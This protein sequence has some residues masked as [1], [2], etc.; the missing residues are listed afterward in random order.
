[1][2]ILKFLY[3]HNDNDTSPTR[4]EGMEMNWRFISSH[5]FEKSPTRLEGMEISIR[6]FSSL[7]CAWSPTRLEGMEINLN[8]CTLN[9]H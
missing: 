5:R 6:S 1:M 3:A 2:E 7:L 8:F 4:L 9:R